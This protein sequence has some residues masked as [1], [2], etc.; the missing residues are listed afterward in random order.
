[1][2]PAMEKCIPVRI[3]NTFN[4]ESNGTL[5]HSSEMLARRVK[6]SPPKVSSLSSSLGAISRD[7]KGVKGFSTVS[8]ISMVNLEGT[9]MIGVPGIASRT[10]QS[11]Y[12]QGV[13]VIL[14]AQASSEYSICMA[15]PS[16]QG[17]IALDAVKKTFRNELQDGLISSV[18]VVS[19]CSI[20]AVVGDNMKQV[21]GVSSRLFT[22]LTK[23]GVN[24]R[25]IAQGSSEHNI[26]VV[27]DS[28]DESRALQAVHAGF[29]L[30]DQTLSVGVIGP[31]VVGGALIKQIRDQVSS[32]KQEFGVDVRVQGIATSKKMLCNDNIDLDN[33]SEMLQSEG[34]EVNLKQFAQRIRNS[35]LPHAVICDCTSSQEVT[36]R[37]VEWIQEGIHLITPNKKANSGP[38][39]YYSAIREAQRGLNTHFFYEANVGAGLPIISSIRDLLRTGDRFLEIQGIFSGTLSYI[40][41][42]FDGSEPFSAIVKGAKELGYTEPDPRDDLSGMDVARKVVILAR[43]IGLEVELEDVPV[44]SLVPDALQGEDVTVSDFMNRLADYDGDLTSMA[45]EA[46]NAGEMLRYVGIVNME[47]KTCSVELKR[48]K[49]D[50]PFGRLRG[51]DNIVTFRTKRYDEQPLVVQGPGA[52]AEVTAAGVFADLLRLAAYLGAPSTANM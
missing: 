46:A 12:E 44:K 45:K 20:L 13:S 23:A 42:S 49:D 4:A 8:D 2:A 15:V 47:T 39:A 6:P 27:V 21:P 10:F 50:H 31:G 22:S 17:R 37:Y 41:N 34:E 7:A 32:L 26:S 9:G 29:Y 30:S 19:R 28:L 38:L 18:D 16:S 36:D 24:I 52:G 11:L 5:V 43:E 48:V 25:A 35:S 33:W 51:S 40:F 3:L 1:M 14:I